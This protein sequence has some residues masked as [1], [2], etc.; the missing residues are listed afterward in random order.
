MK[1]SI[2]VDVEIIIHHYFSG[3]GNLT[4]PY[5]VSQVWLIQHY[6]FLVVGTWLRHMCCDHH[7]NVRVTARQCALTYA[8]AVWLITSNQPSVGTSCVTYNLHTMEY[9]LSANWLN[10][11]LF[12]SQLYLKVEKNMLT[13]SWYNYYSSNHMSQKFYWIIFL[14]FFVYIDFFC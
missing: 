12:L 4:V 8:R 13:K 6:F 10:K 5:A 2:C 14:P 3:G 7:F 11:T 9:F 1:W